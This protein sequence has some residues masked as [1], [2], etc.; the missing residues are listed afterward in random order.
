MSCGYL[1]TLYLCMFGLASLLKASAAV[2][3]SFF[4]KDLSWLALVWPAGLGEDPCPC[5]AANHWSSGYKSLTMRGG[6][7]K[8]KGNFENF[9]KFGFWAVRS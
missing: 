3:I 9:R 1:C 5:W 8:E 6:K 2:P 4:W 7:E